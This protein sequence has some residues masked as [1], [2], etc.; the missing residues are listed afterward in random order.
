MVGQHPCPEADAGFRQSQAALIWQE[1][2]EEEEGPGRGLFSA[3]RRRGG[4][5]RREEERPQ[6]A[7][8]H[9]KPHRIYSDDDCVRYFVLGTLAALF[10]LLLNLLFNLLG[11]HG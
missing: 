11:R 1:L 10:A 3:L 4:A 7:G 2:E 5:R 9:R 8:P 6:G